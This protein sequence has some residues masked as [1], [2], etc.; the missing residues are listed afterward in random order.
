M[1]RVILIARSR[2]P[3]FFLTQFL[4]F[5][6]LVDFVLPFAPPCLGYIAHAEC[7]CARAHARVYI[8]YLPIKRALHYKSRLKDITSE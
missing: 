3:L 1:R 2:S 5:F 4:L 8:E 6:L 7:L